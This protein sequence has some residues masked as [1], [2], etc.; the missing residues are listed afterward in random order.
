M[1]SLNEIEQFVIQQARD[2]ATTSIHRMWK[3]WS[4]IFDEQIC[5]D[6]MSRL[7]E[8]IQTFFDE[9][10][11]ES[12]NRK[13]RI[14]EAIESLRQEANNLRRLLNEEELTDI[15]QSGMPL[16]LV[17]IALDRSLEKMRDKLKT[18]HELIDEYLFEQ[19][20]LC[21]ELG[22]PLRELPKDPLPS[23]AEMSE[24][25]T[26]LDNLRAEKLQ[27]F[28]EIAAMRR[29]IKIWMNQLEIV[30]QSDRQQ[31]LINARNF[32]P[33][34]LNITALRHL[35]E[36]VQSQFNDLKENIDKVRDK[37]QNLWTYLKVSPTCLKRFSKY[38]DYT[39]TTYDKLFAEL[40]RCE[41]LRR[42]NIQ[43]YVDRT[44]VEIIHWWDKC[45]KSEEERSRF[46][47]FKSD[48]YNE[49]L[50][51]LHE[52]ELN[53]LKDFYR[54]N[55]SIFQLVEQRKEMFDKML[56]LEQKSTDPSRYNNRGGKLLEEEKERK[57]IAIQLPKI[58][59]RLLEACKRYE[60]ENQRK[61]TI[62]GEHIEDMIRAQWEKREEGKA[63]N[64]CARKKANQ[65][66]GSKPAST[67][68][69]PKTTESISK[70]ASISNR[71]KPATLGAEN[72]LKISAGKTL[73]ASKL[74]VNMLKRKMPSPKSG[75][76]KRSLL[77]ELNSPRNFLKPAA[78]VSTGKSRLAQK[79]PGKVPTIKVY[80][81]KGVLSVAQK[82]RSRR[83]SQRA[84]RSVSKARPDI[85]TSSSES[86]IQSESVSYEHFEN[87]FEQNTPNRSSLKPGKPGTPA[88]VGVRVNTRRNLRANG[89]LLSVA[90]ST[91]TTPSKI[92]F[93]NPAASSTI[94][95]STMVSPA[96]TTSSGRKLI[97]VS[98]NCPIIF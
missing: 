27:R 65:T 37:L 33:S 48:V 91:M 59:N 96:N 12:E 81:T 51:T 70:H 43:A 49:D 46:S 3:L 5:R 19:E 20:T 8:H 24:F 69:T 53:D 90:S 80:D 34:R 92:T 36:L 79:S 29:E 40:D 50:L 94:L 71:T 78:P 56:I 23:E 82:R 13:R 26:Y 15:Q 11:E 31:E 39:Q 57:R 73:S 41:T 1:D 32:P 60:E 21:E 67:S 38:N 10:Y 61:F 4:E 74:T 14:L 62:F 63:L 83:K 72:T 89:T 77:K 85:V 52:M 35:H 22:E 54:N 17:Q 93:R 45:L 9:V 6:H 18:R 2:I 75:P 68:K 87:F 28:D 66:P 97:P 7:P 88:S 76:A 98:K 25:R 58:E 64:S 95:T 84:R 42:E 47:T 55:E 16:H 44:R 86:T 30:P